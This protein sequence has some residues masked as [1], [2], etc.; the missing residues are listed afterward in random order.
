[1]YLMYQSKPAE[2]YDISYWAKPRAASECAT[3]ARMLDKLAAS[4]ELQVG[5]RLAQ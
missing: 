5:H 4:P 1:V 2:A 3:E